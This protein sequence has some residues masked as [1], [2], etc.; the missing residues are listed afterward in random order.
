[1]SC[2]SVSW[3]ALRDCAQLCSINIVRDV[4]WGRAQETY[5]EDPTLTG[6][7]GAAYVNGMQTPD[8]SW[9]TPAV[10]NVA[11]HFAAYNLE[12]N[13]AGRVSA[14][15]I[16]ASD[17]QYRLSYDAN[18]SEAD[19]MQTFLPAFESLVV[20]AKLRGVMCAY[21]SIN[22]KPLWCVTYR[23]CFTESPTNFCCLPPHWLTGCCAQCK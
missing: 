13:F 17:G 9:P 21:N 23:T 4:R 12:S 10:R 5:G 22:G 15:S 2:V 19:M 16:A 20:D 6:V 7:L 8:P 11:K 18:V 3:V 14:S 1:M